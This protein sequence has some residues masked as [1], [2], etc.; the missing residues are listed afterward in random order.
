MTKPAH[1]PADHFTG[2]ALGRIHLPAFA[3]GVI[4]VITQAVLAREAL[5]AAAGHEL[6]FG[7][8]LTGWLLG[9]ALCLATTWKLGKRL[10]PVWA[11]TLAG[12]L[13]PLSLVALRL[14]TQHL[15]P[16]DGTLP[17]LLAITPVVLLCTLPAGLGL[18]LAFATVYHRAREALGAGALLQVYAA[19]TCGFLAGGVFWTFALAGNVP[20]LLAL[21]LM[22]GA[23]VLISLCEIRKFI[24]VPTVFVEAGVA[25]ACLAAVWHGL[26]PLL[27]TQ[28]PEG[29]ALVETVDGRHARWQVGEYGGEYSFYRN[30]RLTS[31]TGQPGFAAEMVLLP[32]AQVMPSGMES[33]LYIGARLPGCASFFAKSPGVG[34]SWFERDQDYSRLFE[35]YA[36]DGQPGNI[37]LLRKPVLP[38]LRYANGGGEAHWDVIV[39]NLGP[40]T[41][42]EVAWAYDQR[43]LKLCKES[44]R[45]DGV[46]ALSL[47]AEENY[48]SPALRAIH[49]RVLSNLKAVFPQVLV[50]PPVPV[51]YFAG[52]EESALT[53]DPAVIEER[54]A[55]RGV[56][57][58]YMSRYV[59]MDRL[60]QERAASWQALDTNKTEPSPLS[61][62]G[63][64]AELLSTDPRLA[65]TLDWLSANSNWLGIVLAAML[66]IPVLAS[67]SRRPGMPISSAALA[68]LGGFTCLAGEIALAWKLQS[69]TGQLY[70]LL[71][72]LTALVLGGLFAGTLIAAQ[73]RSWVKLQA[74]LWPSLTTVTLALT[75]LLCALLWVLAVALPLCTGVLI[76]MALSDAAASP[77]WIY[78]CDLTGA[79][80]AA[81]VAGTIGMILWG[82]PWCLAALML[83][84]LA[85]V[86][87]DALSRPGIMTA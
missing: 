69:L 43:F 57:T 1:T 47:D 16:A 12:V 40:P 50:T 66:L 52:G 61:L 80:A 24:R 2:Y 38:A 86:L 55:T 77:A 22:P 73:I 48:N 7:V 25:I 53:L 51:W 9:Q 19:E 63:L 8:V 54:L 49:E 26:A 20:H 4:A 34:A 17:T 60:A 74:I 32:L 28:L 37:Q 31:S 23:M 14:A 45:P 27:T 42:P 87:R 30:G 70:W 82:A 41:S 13:A 75:A 67:R 65:A 6:M 71:G 59:L 58:P 21:L 68:F 62:A 78:A 5:S 36:K 3:L 15:A 29:I 39:L 64:R 72:L 35:Q 46:L 10:S 56:E 76:G 44:L 81:L 11:L 84:W 83:V 85:V 18:A 79:A 33:V